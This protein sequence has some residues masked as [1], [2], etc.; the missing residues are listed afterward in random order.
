MEKKEISKIKLLYVTNISFDA[1][2]DDLRR[3]FSV[4]GTVRSIKLLTDPQS[5]KF[6]GCGFVEMSA[7]AEA[8]EAVATL[9]EALLIDRLLTVVV[10]RESKPKEQLPAADK[11]KRP[12]PVASEGGKPKPR[13]FGAAQKVSKSI[14]APAVEGK[15]GRKGRPSDAAQVKPGRSGRPGKGRK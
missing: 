11:R 5:G 8:K 1:T 10:A 3:M 6:R 2:E 13:T 12:R 4:A 15:P 14:S 9:D 7:V